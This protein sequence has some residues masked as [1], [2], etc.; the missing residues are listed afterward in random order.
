MKEH[1]PT[2]RASPHITSS[3]FYKAMERLRDPSKDS[4]VTVWLRSYY[5]QPFT[6]TI[7]PIGALS[8]LTSDNCIGLFLSLKG[9]WCITSTIR[10]STLPPTRST[11]SRPRGECGTS[12]VRFLM[13]AVLLL[14]KRS[15]SSCRGGI[16]NMD[17]MSYKPWGCTVMQ[18]MSNRNVTT[19]MPWTLTG[20]V[21]CYL[22]MYPLSRFASWKV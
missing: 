18:W 8:F 16:M 6:L 2:S 10:G 21:C 11:S 14:L 5:P 12:F 22:L 13:Q 1:V 15:P 7:L 20:T 19:V 4:W 17:S 3:Y 9:T